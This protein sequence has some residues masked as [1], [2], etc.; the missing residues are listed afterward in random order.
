MSETPITPELR[1]E[2]QAAGVHPGADDW[3]ALCE[4]AINA[5]EV[6]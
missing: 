4:E 6:G 5:A 3:A 1:A 2:L